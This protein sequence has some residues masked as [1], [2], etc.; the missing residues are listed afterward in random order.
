MKLFDKIKKKL[1]PIGKLT[2]K[3]RSAIT[4][5]K[6]QKCSDIDAEAGPRTVQERARMYAHVGHVPGVICIASDFEELPMT[7]QIGVL[8][9]EIGHVLACKG[10][11]PQA[12]IACKEKL[13]VTIQY[14]GVLEL[15]YV[16][17]LTVVWIEKP[18][19]LIPP[20]ERIKSLA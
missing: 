8:L 11:E 17:P 15:Q 9:H 16:D 1:L 2:E 12:D 18:L 7:H 14:D 19:T 13:G 5:L 3:D 20:K 10:G 4:A 6:V